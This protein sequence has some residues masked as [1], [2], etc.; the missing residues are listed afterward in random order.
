M[1]DL[2]KLLACVPKLTWLDVGDPRTSEYTPNK[3]V[4]AYKEDVWATLLQLVPEIATFF[5]IKLFHPVPSVIVTESDRSKKKKNQEIASRLASK[6]K[7]LR[8]LDHWEDGRSKVII[9]SRE[10]GGEKYRV[11]LM[12]QD[13]ADSD[14]LI[15]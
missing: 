3:G 7:K 1:D 13:N 10:D 15:E 8:R 9:L 11:R 2:R 5:G 14:S 4:K 6:C 12:R